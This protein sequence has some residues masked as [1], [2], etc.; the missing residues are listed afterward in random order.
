MRAL[1]DINIVLDVL[2]KR[3]PWQAEADAI[4]Q[5]SRDGKLSCVVASHSIATVFYIAR[6]Q[7]GTDQ[8][9]TAVRECLQVF[10]IATVDRSV[11]EAADAL[12]GAD[13]EDNIQIAAAVRDGADAIVTRDPR[14]FAACPID[15]LSPVDL[16]GRLI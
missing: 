15:V 1:L 7:V 11:W 6:R 16:A 9:R 14:G 10:E 3:I 4:L 5:A 8:A 2:L 12:P 13:F